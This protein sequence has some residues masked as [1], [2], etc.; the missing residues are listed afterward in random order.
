[1]YAREDSVQRIWV[2]NRLLGIKVLKFFCRLLYCVHYRNS[3]DR[4]RWFLAAKFWLL[5][6]SCLI[7]ECLTWW[8]VACRRRSVASSTANNSI[9]STSD[10]VSWR[11]LRFCDRFANVRFCLRCRGCKTHSA[12]IVWGMRWKQR[13]TGSV[14]VVVSCALSAKCLKTVLLAPSSPATLAAT[15][16][17]PVSFM[18]E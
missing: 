1:V 13:L 2:V 4:V 7:H 9:V 6:R 11:R 15:P 10:S 12:S 14:S 3:L 17:R 16:F 5:S 18:C 8:C